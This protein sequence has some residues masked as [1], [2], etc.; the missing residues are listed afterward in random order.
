M[1]TVKE[2]IDQR[3]RQIHVHS[4]M[5]YHMDTS[6][7]TD[8]TFD[9]WAKELADLHA[10]NPRLVKQGYLWKEFATWTGDTGMHLPVT[11]WAVGMAEWLLSHPNGKKRQW[12]GDLS[13]KV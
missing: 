10:N 11:D 13:Y 4:V 2:K 3:R 6:I 5:Y 9:R 8:A 7:V 1:Q 12:D